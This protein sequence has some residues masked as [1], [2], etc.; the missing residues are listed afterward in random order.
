MHQIYTMKRSDETQRYF[1]DGILNR[2]NANN[3]FKVIFN[4]TGD[5]FERAL[6]VNERMFFN[7]MINVFLPI[8]KYAYPL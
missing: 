8:L 3:L 2:H 4:S 7:Q 5:L 1:I 6:I